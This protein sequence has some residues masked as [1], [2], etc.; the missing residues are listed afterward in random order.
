MRKIITIIFA[1]VLISSCSTFS[2]PEPETCDLT[3]SKQF[4]DEMAIIVG[5]L[6]ENVHI[7]GT[8]TN[9]DYSA[10]NSEASELLEK[11][12]EIQAPTCL[13]KSKGLLIS[14]IES[15]IVGIDL[16]QAG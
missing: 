15:T 9:P 3:D 12:K 14:T 8:E 2:K 11:A 6:R 1:L 16:F 4:M 5:T 7:L 13:E 10:I